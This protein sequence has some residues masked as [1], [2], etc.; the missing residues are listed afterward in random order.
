MPSQEPI[1]AVPAEP[2][3][4]NMPAA[5]DGG[6]VSWPLDGTIWGWSCCKLPREALHF[7]VIIVMCYFL[8]S[9]DFERWAWVEYMS[10]VNI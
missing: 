5:P 7:I 4:V 6:E 1:D 9:Y 2:K 10:F 3:D 8:M